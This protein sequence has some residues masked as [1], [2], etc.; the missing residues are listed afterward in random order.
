M[1]IISKGIGDKVS[2]V[3]SCAIKDLPRKHQKHRLIM[4]EGD[5]TDGRKVQPTVRRRE[6]MF[7]VLSFNYPSGTILV[8]Y[9]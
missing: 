7:R 1:S 8:L 3:I 6:R 2:N 9:Q 4:Q 5:P